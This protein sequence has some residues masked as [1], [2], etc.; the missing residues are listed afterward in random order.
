[1]IG[2]VASIAAVVTLLS[3]VVA[4]YYFLQRRQGGRIN[5][6]ARKMGIEGGPGLNEPGIPSPLDPQSAQEFPGNVINKPTPYPMEKY[7]STPTSP[8]FVQ[9][10]PNNYVQQMQSLNAATAD[11]D[12]I[13]NASVFTPNRGTKA[14]SPTMSLSTPSSRGV[15]TSE[16][17]IGKREQPK[18]MIPVSPL[19][20]MSD[21]GDSIP[22]SYVRAG[23]AEA[24]F[25]AGGGRDRTA[26]RRSSVTVDILGRGVTDRGGRD[27][28]SD[29]SL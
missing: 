13:L 28:N 18:A 7:T 9:S 23:I 6:A 8:Y 16:P 11:L 29:P 12:Q 26:A 3:V 2:I 27:G 25:E 10:M 20:F 17:P 19:S 1:M 4:M 15:Q 22:A 14:W 21:F 24:E 5:R